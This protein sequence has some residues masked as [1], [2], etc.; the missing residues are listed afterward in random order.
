MIQIREILEFFNQVSEFY[1]IIEKSF[2]DSEQLFRS[3]HD[4]V[5]NYLKKNVSEESHSELYEIQSKLSLAIRAHQCE[6][7]TKLQQL[8]SLFE[9]LIQKATIPNPNIQQIM[10]DSKQFKTPEQ[11]P[12]LV[13]ADTTDDANINLTHQQR[14]EIRILNKLKEHFQIKLKDAKNEQE[15][16]NLKDDI[17]KFVSLQ[18][19]YPI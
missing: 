15:A 11:R 3:S 16:Q 18:N 4:Q 13:R 12:K 2:E 8:H 10:E 1:N 9:K 14:Y 5:I 19:T 6:R 17:L 7:A